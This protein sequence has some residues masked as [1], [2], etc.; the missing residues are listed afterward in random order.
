MCHYCTETAT[1]MDHTV[2]KSKGGREKVPCCVPCNKAKA[3]IPYEDWLLIVRH[4][5]L[6]FVKGNGGKKALAQIDLD[7][8][9]YQDQARA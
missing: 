1:T 6:K 4:G 5:L 8:L 2:P 9:R 7:E 3:D